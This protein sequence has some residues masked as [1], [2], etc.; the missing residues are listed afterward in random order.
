MRIHGDGSFLLPI[1]KEEIQGA[2]VTITVLIEYVPAQQRVMVR[3]AW[4]TDGSHYLEPLSPENQ[5]NYVKVFAGVDMKY[6]VGFRN[7]IE[8]K[9]GTD[10]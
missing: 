4:T 10:G 2:M 7:L 8:A 6:N 5:Q 1:T 9:E 3:A